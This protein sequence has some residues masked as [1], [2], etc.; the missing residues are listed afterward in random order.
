MRCSPGWAFIRRKRI[1]FVIRLVVVRV[2]GALRALRLCRPIGPY[3]HPD[4]ITPTEPIDITE[5]NPAVQVKAVGAEP[6]AWSVRLDP[7]ALV[8]ALPVARHHAIHFAESAI[9]SKHA[10]YLRHDRR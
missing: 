1:Q 2:P 3:V 5:V 4:A 9:E 8:H 6:Y 10:H 7:D